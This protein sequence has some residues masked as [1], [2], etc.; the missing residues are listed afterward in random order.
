MPFFS[1]L[2]YSTSLG[3]NLIYFYQDKNVERKLFLFLLKAVKK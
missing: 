1:K 2:Q 3:T